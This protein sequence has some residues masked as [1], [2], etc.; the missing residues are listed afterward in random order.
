LKGGI[1]YKLQ[2]SMAKKITTLS[3]KRESPDENNRYAKTV[4]IIYLDILQKQGHE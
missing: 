1:K 4:C 2:F 3:Y